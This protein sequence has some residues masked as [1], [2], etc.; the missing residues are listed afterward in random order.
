MAETSLT[1]PGISHVIDFGDARVSRYSH[2]NKIQRLPIEKI[3]QAAARQRAGRC[4]RTQAGICIRLYSEEDLL[5]RP[6]F[7]EPEIL[8][9]NLATVILQ[10][11]LMELGEVADFPFLDVPKPKLVSDGYRLLNEL[12]ALNQNQELSDIGRDIARIPLDPRLARMLIAAEQYHCVSELCIICA[13]LSI[14]DPRER[15]QDAMEKADLVHQKFHH[16]SSDFMMMLKLWD[17][18]DI[19]RKELS[20][21]AFQKLCR[22]NF[23]SASRIREWFEMHQQLIELCQSMKFTLNQT[24]ADYNTT[25]CAIVS[26]LLSHIGKK[27]V[28]G[29]AYQGARN[30]EYYLFPGSGVFTSAPEWDRCSRVNGNL[31]TLCSPDCENRS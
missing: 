8:R 14:Q 31:E 30:I 21:K 29:H 28:K 12:S 4:G 25:H 15:P 2:K 3:S 20:R 19:K 13:F 9:T 24:A 7:T 18:L 5:Q 17:F 16:Q 26:G 11:K 10:M 23:L 1:I 22:T 6:A 27:D